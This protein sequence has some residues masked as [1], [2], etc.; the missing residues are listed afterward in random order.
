MHHG[1]DGYTDESEQKDTQGD[2]S[3]G[4]MPTCNKFAVPLCPEL[5]SK[6]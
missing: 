5:L 2:K 4:C 1:A 3:V 6:R